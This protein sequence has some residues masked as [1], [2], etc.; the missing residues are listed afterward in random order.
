MAIVKI[1]KTNPVPYYYQLKEIILNQVEN[2]VWKIGD[3]IPSEYELCNAYQVSRTVVRQALDE[4]VQEGLLTKQ[5][6]K[7]SFVADP[8]ISETVTFLGSF[9]AK[10]EALGY[11][12]QTKVLSAEIC[13][14]SKRVAELLEIEPDEQVV[15]IRRLRLVE[16][17]PMVLQTICLPLSRVPDLLCEDLS[18]SITSI[19]QKK[20]ELQFKSSK[21]F[22]EPTTASG[23]EASLLGVAKGT[24]FML[25]WGLSYS[26]DSK[27]IRYS[28]NLYRADRLM[29]IV[30]NYML[31]TKPG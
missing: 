17:T 26:E 4:L 28:R 31:E 15:S 30:E 7:G 11:K 9:K 25:I 5:K 12:T 2:G 19:L 14:A 1:D 16:Q 22:M 27:P 3:Q 18:Q 10:M 23:Q 29:F 13:L 20:Y 6:G 21:V 8:K 24:P